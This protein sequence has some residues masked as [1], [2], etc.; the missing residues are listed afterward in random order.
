MLESTRAD[1]RAGRN[2]A[3]ARET[4][5]ELLPKLPPSRGSSQSTLASTL[6]PKHPCEYSGPTTGPKSGAGSLRREGPEG[7]PARLPCGF[8]CGPLR[9]PAG[10]PLE[11]VT[12]LPWVAGLLQRQYA[13]YPLP[14]PGSTAPG[15]RF[16]RL[17][18]SFRAPVE[19]RAGRR[20][21]GQTHVAPTGAVPATRGEGREVGNGRPG[22]AGVGHRRPANARPRGSLGRSRSPLGAS[23]LRLGAPFGNA[24]ASSRRESLAPLSA[25]RHP[26]P[27]LGRRP[28]GDRA[29]SSSSPDRPPCGDD[30]PV[31]PP[32]VL[33][34]RRRR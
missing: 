23:T 22:T 11:A 12:D 10:A 16:S 32:P 4:P 21:L 9:G 20:G 26:T 5:R 27:R 17:C 13:R 30:P 34:Y 1:C 33:A 31:P 6:V 18:P 25:S 8:R 2:R 28:G 7:P 14:C 24:R 19:L 15:L 29:I 3:R